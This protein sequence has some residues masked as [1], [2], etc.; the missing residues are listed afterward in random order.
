MKHNVLFRVF[1]TSIILFGFFIIYEAVQMFSA[2]TSLTS[3][4]FFALL[5]L[6]A[7]S[8]VIQV[9][10]KKYV[11][12]GFA[13][14]L[15]AILIFDPYTAAAVNF[16]GTFFSIYYSEGKYHH[17]FNSSVYKRLFNGSAYAIGSLVA[18]NAYQMSHSVLPAFT[19]AGFGIVNT[20][21]ANSV[22]PAGSLNE[23]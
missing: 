15:A 2:E 11:S 1:T 23:T 14:G 9:N 13:I 5:S 21:N 4:L 17:I 19:V 7:E 16:L 20:S 12:L 10:E 6:L 22:S 18:G 8:M 3:V